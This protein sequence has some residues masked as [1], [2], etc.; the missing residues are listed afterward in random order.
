LLH[1]DPD[2]GAAIPTP[3]PGDQ[4]E[5]ACY[6]CLLSYRNQPDHQL[7]DRSLV[8]PLLKEW[9]HAIVTAATGD[10]TPGEE[11]SALDREAESEL[12]REFVSYLGDRGYRL[13]SRAGFLVAEAGTRPDFLYDD[14]S[15]AIYV[16][17]PPHDYPDRQRRDAEITTKLRDLGW[18]V[19]RFSHRD[20]WA[21]TIDTYKWVFGDGA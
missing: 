17:G 18:T 14:A 15:A 6:R 1:V 7:L 4:C 19:I 8:L 21:Q 11:R 9:S 3:P 16:D 10:R 13:P 5:A 2:T 20:D 12:E